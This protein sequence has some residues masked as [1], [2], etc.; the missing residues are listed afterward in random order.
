VTLITVLRRELRLSPGS[1]IAFSLLSSL[2]TVTII[3]S[4]S[5]ASEAASHGKVS[6]HAAAVFLAS[7]ATFI[8]AQSKLMRMVAQETEWMVHR[9]RTRLFHALCVAETSA[10]QSS[11]RGE[12]FATITQRT[13]TLSRNLFMLVAGAQ[14]AVLVILI[15]VYLAFLSLAAFFM[16]AAMS[17]LIIFLHVVRMRGVSGRDAAAERNEAELFESLED[18]L[19]SHREL[20]LSSAR[21]DSMARTV[22][23][24][25]ARVRESRTLGKRLWAR[26]ASLLQ[27]AFYSL[28]GVTVFVAPAFSNHF[29]A[30]AFPGIM[31]SLFLIGPVGSMASALSIAGDVERALHAVRA[32]EASLLGGT[33]RRE[34]ES[35][36]GEPRAMSPS[37]VDSLEVRDLAFAY[38][39]NLGEPGFVV[40]PLTASFRNQQV[41][42][43]TGGNGSGKTTL[44]QLLTGLLQPT[45]GGLWI[46]GER[47]AADQVQ[48]WRDSISTVFS[49]GHLFSRLYGLPA[50]SMPKAPSWINRLGLQSS[51]SFE[52][53]AFSR[54]DLS[55][56]Q[57]KRLALIAA[58]LED[59]PVMILDEW[60]ADQDPHWR[61]VFYEELIPQFRAEGRLVICITHD[62]AWFH[63]ADQ[64][65]H[66][67]EGH[68][69]PRKDDQG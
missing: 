5:T 46:N 27:V 66:M 2:S 3:A 18:I 63:I 55:T 49:D 56:G 57:R 54:L 39:H 21:A 44:V 45:S 22:A 64:R 52:D 60:A 32:L 4:V 23:K 7:M 11:A 13:Q 15:G 68:L 36:D 34:A 16:V 69:M 38:P 62:D 17:V 53:G 10:L 65:L 30:V 1:L 20:R 47:L 51:V 12:V 42:F 40:G 58:I 35:E 31:A 24:A 26:E 6:L 67:S 14:Q 37:R 28:V 9:M 8:A 33:N 61:R 29:H 43:I 59:K 50:E 25:S 19:R 41:T 48:A